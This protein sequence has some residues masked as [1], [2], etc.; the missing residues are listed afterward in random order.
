MISKLLEQAILERLN[1]IPTEGQHNLIK[2]LAG[3]IIQG[4]ND[5]VFVLTGYAGTGKTST[6][7][8]I[9][10]A[11]DDFKIKTSLMAPTGRAAKVLSTFSGKPAYT[12]HKKIYKQKSS[13]DGFG[14]FVLSKNLTPGV[15]FIV[16]EASMIGTQGNEALSFGSGNLLNDLLEYVYSNDGCKLILVGD[17]AQLP[18][19]SVSESPALSK[20]YL[21]STGFSVKGSLLTDIVRQTKNSG[22]LSNATSIRQLISERKTELPQFATENFLDIVK[23][24]G[25]ELISELNTCYEKYGIEQT[26]V[27]TRSNKRANLYNDGIRKSVLFRDES[28]TVGD[29]L[30]VV[31]NNYFWLADEEETDFIANGDIVQVLRLGKYYERYG[32]K[33]VDATICL[34]DLDRREI[35]TKLI[36]ETLSIETA[37]LSS[38]D[39]KNFFYKVYED[40]QHIKPKKVGYDS[41]R[42]NQ[43]FNAL[44]VKFAY[45]I[46]CH[47]AQGGQWKAVFIDQGYFTNDM[48]NLE[49]LRW[50]YTAVTRATEKLYLVNFNKDFFQ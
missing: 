19:V 22:I 40:Y 17:T 33:F 50:L 28:I 9:I 26:I 12:I 18:P 49:Y 47:K 41:V 20:D 30:M 25:N 23:I 15:I 44:Q 5:T 48:L 45:A 32:Y 10:N 16:D 37:A 8:A 4:A 42:N 46:T 3:Y 13:K 43:F 1:E 6:I 27:I 35:E 14:K 2:Q 29:Y 34:V 36:L 11:L 39:N 24:A 38:E 21:L 7:A 31:K